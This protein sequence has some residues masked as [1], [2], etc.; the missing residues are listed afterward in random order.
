MKFNKWTLGLAALGVVSLASAVQAEEK[1]PVLSALSQTTISGYV[2]TSFV[3]RMGNN[4]NRQLVPLGMVPLPGTGV[5]M[6]PVPG[7]LSYP[8]APASAVQVVDTKGNTLVPPTRLVPGGRP[9]TTKENGFNLNVVGLTFSKDMDEAEWAAG[10]KV[11]LLFGPDATGYNPSRISAGTSDFAVKQAYIDL[12]APVGNGLDFRLGVFD[13]PL[14]YEAF[15]SYKNPNYTRSW[16]FT[17]S[18][19]ELTGAQV[20]YKFCEEFSA[21]AG[22]AEVAANGINARTA[23]AGSLGSDWEKAYFGA[24]TLTAPESLGFL[25]GSTLTVGALNGLGNGEL[26]QIYNPTT[27]KLEGIWNSDITWL[28]AGATLNTPLEGLKVGVA[29]DY[30]LTG[31]QNTGKA[32]VGAMY[33]YAVSGYITYQATEKLKLA[34]RGE[35]AQSTDGVWYETGRTGNDINGN[36]KHFGDQNPKNRLLGLTATVDY[37]LWAN[38]VTRLEFRWDHDLTGQHYKPAD[39]TDPLKFTTKG[40]FGWDDRNN[41]MLALNVIYKF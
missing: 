14:G 17:L 30:M 36:L 25:K 22:I 5:N 10:Y 13:S 23:R 3:W 11:D 8:L 38:V 12:R 27:D 21:S 34:L 40:P 18:P 16:G 1:S 19:K 6:Q 31:H 32:Y 35:Y 24:I 41:F 33:A 20:S 2:D 37:S 39:P 29:Y 9:M 15:E 4:F 28:Y 26:V 7:G